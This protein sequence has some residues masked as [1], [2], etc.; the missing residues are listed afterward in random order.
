M[1]WASI[2]CCNITYLLMVVLVQ[3]LGLLN[4]VLAMFTSFYTHIYKPTFNRYVH[5]H[6]QR[7]VLR[8]NSKVDIGLRAKHYIL[9]WFLT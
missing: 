9:V 2:V 7:S 4:Q 1:L 3:A 5:I 6:I 8:S